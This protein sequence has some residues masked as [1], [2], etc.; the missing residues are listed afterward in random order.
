MIRLQRIYNL[1]SI[2]AIILSVWMFMGFTKHFYI[3]FGT[4]L[5]TEGPAHIAVL[6]PIS[7]FWRKGI[8]IGLQT[9]WN[10]REHDFWNEHDPEDLECKP[11]SSRGGHEGGWRAWPRG[12][13][14]LPHGHLAASLTS[15]PSLLDHVYSKKDHP[16]GFIPFDIPFRRNIEIGK[17][18][19]ICTLTMRSCNSRIP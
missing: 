16:E 9:E 14:A 8:S 4:N 3:I 19:A 15:T 5:L 7:V 17:K 2:L 18:I 10:L 1:W 6:L 12:R 11:R 13:A